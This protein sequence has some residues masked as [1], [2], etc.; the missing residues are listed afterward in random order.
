MWG[1]EGLDLQRNEEIALQA[2]T[3]R[4]VDGP[5]MLHLSG[6]QD[7]PFTIQS[8]D[9]YRADNLIKFSPH[10]PYTVYWPWWVLKTWVLGERASVRGN[11]PSFQRELAL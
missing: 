7:F 9:V 11:S 10:I 5:R 1:R 6:Y 2:D 8:A 3:T 4:E